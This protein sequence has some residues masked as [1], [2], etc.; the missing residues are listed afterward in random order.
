MRTPVAYPPE[1]DAVWAIH[2]RLRHDQAKQPAFHAWN[3]RVKTDG[4]PSG[5]LRLATEHFEQAMIR[6]RRS[7]DKIMHARRFFGPN[8]EWRPYLG[9]PPPAPPV[10][11]DD[12]IGWAAPS[13]PE[14][15]K[16]GDRTDEL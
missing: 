3:A 11:G 8:E 15:F 1:F 6:Q 14:D 12:R 10:A 13:K 5:D 4:V 16:G 7:P 9:E 2:H